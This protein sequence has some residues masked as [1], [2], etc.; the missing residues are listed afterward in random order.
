MATMLLYKSTGMFSASAHRFIQN[1]AQILLKKVNARDLLS[2]LNSEGYICDRRKGKM[3]IFT[4][5][6]S[7]DV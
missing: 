5:A 2:N 6:S 1:V 7:R 4:N 3:K